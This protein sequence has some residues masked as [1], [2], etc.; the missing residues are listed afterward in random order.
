MLGTI[1]IA[2]GITYLLRQFHRWSNAKTP[3]Q[4]EDTAVTTT[5]GVYNLES[6]DAPRLFGSKLLLF[7]KILRTP[8][9]GNALLSFL[10]RKNKF[11]RMVNFASSS[12]SEAS[13]MMPM[14]YPIHVMSQEEKSLHETMV[15]ESPLSIPKL[16]N[17]HQPRTKLDEIYDI[18]RYWSIHDYIS[19]YKGRE[20]SPLFVAQ[21]L[22]QK[23]NALNEYLPLIVHM[24]EEEIVRNATES[25]LRYE[26]N[27]PIGV[28]DGIPI[29]VKDE[30]PVKGY[31]VTKG[32][33]FLTDIALEDCPC[34]AKL[35]KAGAIIVGKTNQHELGL[36]TTGYNR[37]YESARNPHNHRH[38][39]GGSSSGSAA[40]VSSGLVPVAIGKDGGGSIRIP[41]ALCGVV[42]LKPTFQRITYDSTGGDSVGCIGPIATCLNDIALVYAIMA[43]PLA[44]DHRH[45]SHFQPK[46]HLH[47][48][49]SPPRT[50]DDIR[51]GFFRAH[52]EDAHAQM[53]NAT[54][55]TIDHLRSLGATIVEIE[56]PHLQE[57]HLSHAITIL[58]ET[59]TAVHKYHDKHKND[60]SG[61]IQI[62]LELAKS[63]TSY[64]F[65]CAQKIK[66]YAM[67]YM[68]ELF[69]S[70]MD[71]LISPATAS[72]A[73]L[74]PNELILQ[75]ESNLKQTAE[76]MKY[77]ILGNFIGIPGLVLPPVDY[78][79]ETKLPI[80]VLLQ[81]AH[82]REDLLLRVG[83]ACE[84]MTS[85]DMK[86]PK[87]YVGSGLD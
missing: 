26:R 12:T 15:N 76:L 11:Y 41:S 82:W 6:I 23:R 28:L 8:I 37:F 80:S 32:T 31:P 44:S 74:F 4:G 45:L 33:S 27:S 67:S 56:I 58:S 1:F 18:F 17:L 86:K 66:A 39:T 34:I 63:F 61:E 52:V 22:I 79:D 49:I 51:V 78:D 35:R 84:S 46:V 62:T 81:A 54:M 43:G 7:P 83:K 69:S 13:N 70:R 5:A 87:L 38:Y 24:N 16:A 2:L 36:G 42:G 75:G 3:T 20:I 50:L 73:P 47:N 55:K 72:I 19:K 77:C 48:F 21:V 9:L 64:E 40:V 71:I 59:Y 85:D 53:I 10:K 29:A 25:T 30:I 60:Y 57:I 14:Y 68:E 65:V